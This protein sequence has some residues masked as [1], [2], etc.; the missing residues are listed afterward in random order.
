MA[1]ANAALGHSHVGMI[2]RDSFAV[3]ETGVDLSSMY[4]RN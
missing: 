1:T 3:E 4:G 2:N